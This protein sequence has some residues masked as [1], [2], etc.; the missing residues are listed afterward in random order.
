MRVGFAGTPEFAVRALAAIID[1]GFTIPLCL[2][3][4]DRPKG[5][6]LR[7]V[8]PPVK[9]LA[10]AH[11]IDVAQP[12]SL[13][14]P[15]AL[16]PLLAVPL[17]VLVVAAYGLILPQAVL[18]WPRHGCINIHASRLPRWR[19]AAP[20]QR[21]IEAGDTETGVTIMRMDAGLDTGPVVSVTPVP[22]DPRDTGGSLHDKLAA[23]GA[24]AIVAALRRLE[25]SGT[26]P[27]VPQPDAG[28]T[29]A[30]RIGKEEAAIDWTQPA[31]AIERRIRAF[32]PVPGT[33]ANLGGHD[34]KLWSAEVVACAVPAAPGTVV[35]A[36]R[37]GIDVACGD[38]AARRG[39]RIREIQP[40][41]GAR[42][43]AGAFAA[44]RR[45]AP[46]MSFRGR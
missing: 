26:L 45:L 17:D 25:A 44:G 33:T 1:A 35:A 24:Q 39:L 16:A 10:A 18:D 21:A 38:P 27:A 11:G 4:P 34:V 41:G 28:V 37:A 2:T 30:A 32:D 8:P 9:T 5:R 3:R 20:I 12:A 6:G 13:K 22:I 23:A 46:G 15:E 42:M 14:S 43:T 40:A 31:E 29:Y 7:L 36:G 19:G